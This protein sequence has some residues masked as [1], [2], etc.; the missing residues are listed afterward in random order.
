MRSNDIKEYIV[1]EWKSKN[2]NVIADSYSGYSKNIIT[3][4]SANNKYDSKA[5][6]TQ[7]SHEK[8]HVKQKDRTN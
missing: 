8:E 4:L 5:S 6:P 7:R 1:E 2:E 3:E